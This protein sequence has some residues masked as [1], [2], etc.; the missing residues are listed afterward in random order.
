MPVEVITTGSSVMYNKTVEGFLSECVQVFPGDI[1][2]DEDFSEWEKVKD[3][4]DKSLT[5]CFRYL[6]PAQAKTKQ[7]DA[8][9]LEALDAELGEDVDPIVASAKRAAKNDDAAKAD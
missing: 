4:T 9:E 3:K 1:I 7:K 6:T 8:E 2:A 5:Q